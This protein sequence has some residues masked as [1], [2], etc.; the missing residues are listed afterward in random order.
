MRLGL[1]GPLLRSSVISI[2]TRPTA[3]GFY[4]SALWCEWHCASLSPLLCC[5][6][7]DCQRVSGVC[8]C[9]PVPCPAAALEA[10]RACLVGVCLER[11]SRVSVLWWQYHM[12]QALCHHMPLMQR[13]SEA[14]PGPRRAPQSRFLAAERVFTA[15]KWQTE[16]VGG[17]KERMGFLTGTENKRLRA[18]CR[19]GALKCPI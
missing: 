4:P 5:I 17:K 2:T 7:N 11:A 16:Q 18:F 19:G 10:V 15:E 14:W 1:K 9:V 3:W 13:W 8:V 12:T 6:L